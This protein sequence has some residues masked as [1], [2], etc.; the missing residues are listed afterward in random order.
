MFASSI[1]CIC[2]GPRD[3][4]DGEQNAFQQKLLTQEG[5]LKKLSSDSRTIEVAT[6]LDASP[7]DCIFK[8]C[9]ATAFFASY[10]QCRRARGGIMHCQNEVTL[11]GRR[12]LDRRSEHGVFSLPGGFLGGRH[13]PIFF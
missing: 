3:H 5:F 8:V 6:Q 13:G 11:F 7:N 1:H 9:R 2:I 10:L 4:L 12:A